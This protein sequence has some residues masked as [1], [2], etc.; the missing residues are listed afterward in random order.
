MAGNMRLLASFIE[1]S[2]LRL[3]L[4]TL[5]GGDQTLN[6]NAVLGTFKFP[7]AG[8]VPCAQA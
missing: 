3:G 1:L 7:C 6:S 8:H 2:S 5:G 4:F